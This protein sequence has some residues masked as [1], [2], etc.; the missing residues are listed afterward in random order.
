LILWSR[1]V[2]YF[3]LINERRIFYD[4]RRYKE[5]LKEAWHSVTEPFGLEMTLLSLS[6]GTSMKSYPVIGEGSEGCEGIT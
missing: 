5:L 3:K 2:C 4:V 1:K 6:S